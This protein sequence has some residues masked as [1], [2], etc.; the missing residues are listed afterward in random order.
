MWPG[1]RHGPRHRYLSRSSPEL[2][3]NV[4]RH[5]D[6]TTFFFFND[7]ATTEIYTLSLHDA[8]P[9]SAAQLRRRPRWQ[10]RLAYVYKLF[11]YQ[12]SFQNS[13]L[14]A[15]IEYCRAQP[16]TGCRQPVGELGPDTGSAK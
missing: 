3:G 1:A 12:P 14:H 5:R 4:F 9:I 6:D 11:S 8:L 16:A 2:Q 13:N 7:T 10:L 15:R